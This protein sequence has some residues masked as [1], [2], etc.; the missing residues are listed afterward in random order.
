MYGTLLETT[1]NQA[2]Q[3]K[4]RWIKGLSNEIRGAEMEVGGSK[5][6]VKFGIEL[7]WPRGFQKGNIYDGK[8]TFCKSGA[9]RRHL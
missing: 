8:L 9:L 5:V 6:I 4:I 2:N 1:E 7:L 3:V